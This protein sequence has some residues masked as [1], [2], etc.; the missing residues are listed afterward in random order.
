MEEDRR[1][2]LRED[3]K[4]ESE[5]RS[6]DDIINHGVF[7]NIVQTFIL[8]RPKAKSYHGGNPLA[9]AYA[10]EDGEENKLISSWLTS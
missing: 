7:Y 1:K 6:K 10:Q 8:F 5:E 9:E 3:Q 2:G 4:D